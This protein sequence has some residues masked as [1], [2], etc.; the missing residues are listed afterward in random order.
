MNHSLPAR[1]HGFFAALIG[2]GRPLFAFVALSLILCGAFALFLS[3]SGH[4]LPHDVHY[5]GMTADDLCSMK[6]CRIV[7]FMFHDRVSFGGALVAIGSLY[8]WVVEFPL[9][10]REPWAWLALLTSG[11]IGFASFLAYLGYGYLDVWHA[12]AT[13]FL[14]PCFVGGLILSFRHLPKPFSWKSII[15]PGASFPWKSA[16]G[17]G[18]GCLLFTAVGMVSAGATITVVGMTNVFVPQDLGFLGLKPADLN[19]INPHLVPLIAHDRAGF[20]GALCCCGSLILC[21]V[22]CSAPC[23]SLWQVLCVAGTIGFAAA[24]GVHPVI[25]YMDFSHLAP[26]LAGALI[27]ALGLAFS[28]KPMF[29]GNPIIS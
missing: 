1:D 26:A 13:L 10:Q 12:V 25:G 19:A 8:L 16:A 20:G 9:R 7:H 27:F 6:Q 5:L 21:I 11:T 23:R 24:I 29:R 28:F 2:D 18:R 3:V 4:F 15:K 14:L 17:F 22:W